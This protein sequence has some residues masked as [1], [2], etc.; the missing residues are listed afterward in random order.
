MKQATINK[1]IIVVAILLLILLFKILHL[2]QYLTLSYLKESREQF[3]LLYAE[4]T[5][6]V[7]A[8][9]MLIY[10]LATAL[11]LPG[12]VILTLAGGALFGLVTGTIVISFASTIGA[13]LACM[14]SR[15]LL[16]DWVQARFGEK[17]ER[18]NE[19]IEQEGGFY[20]FTLRLIPVFPFFVI[21]L[22]MGLT[23][24]KLSTYYW[25]SQLGMLPG[26]LVYV[27]AGKELGKLETLAGI[28]SPS[29]IFSFVLLGLFPITVKKIV[30][31]IKRKE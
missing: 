20:L 2:D 23:R 4:R 14:V 7:I 16:R 13:T 26:T 9:Y 6:L 10:I 21:N 24:I 25:V 31:R 27:N 8:G 11:S 18:I 1:I 17:L 29:L 19:G 5:G 3:S 12:A 30:G 28:L 15:F 22:A